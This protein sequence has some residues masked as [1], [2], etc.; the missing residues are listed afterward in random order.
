MSETNTAAQDEAQG[1]IQ[2]RLHE[3]LYVVFHKYEDEFVNSNSRA[4]FYWALRNAIDE[5]FESALNEVPATTVGDS[6]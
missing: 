4:R 1:E 6:K 5:E 2:K 3:K